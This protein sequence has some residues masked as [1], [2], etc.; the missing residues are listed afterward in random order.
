ML[1][2]VDD[3]LEEKR[4]WVL[5]SRRHVYDRPLQPFGLEYKSSTSWTVPPG[6]GHRHQTQVS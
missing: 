4:E 6:A 1:V 3:G 2:V 5:P